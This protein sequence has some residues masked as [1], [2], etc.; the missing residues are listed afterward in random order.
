MAEQRDMYKMIL[1]PCR[2]CLCLC[3][4]GIDPLDDGTDDGSR[5]TFYGVFIRIS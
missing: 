3:H 5:L 4:E 1:I 2:S